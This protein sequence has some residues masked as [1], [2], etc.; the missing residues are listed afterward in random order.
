MS[1]AGLP[2]EAALFEALE[3][4]WPPEETV[5]VAGCRLRFAPGAGSRVNSARLLGRLDDAALDAALDA[6]VAGY[7]ERGQAPMLQLGA[8]SFDKAAAARA[9]E[10]G[11]SEFD[12]CLL[13]AAEIDS[14]ADSARTEARTLRVNTPIA[15]LDELWEQGDGGPERR[16]VMAR[17]TGPSQVISARVTDRLAGAVFAS[18]AGPI[19]F[20]H[21]LHTTEEARRRGVGRALMREAARVGREAGARWMAVSVRIGNTPARTLFEA[22]GFTP[23]GGYAYWRRDA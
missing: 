19:C 14:V 13:A 20:E 16:A 15:A 2:D 11:F 3:A 7:A 22:L 5:D 17:A 12:P 10:R 9:A 1:A 8:S 18:V 21:A 4:T 23:V 6:I